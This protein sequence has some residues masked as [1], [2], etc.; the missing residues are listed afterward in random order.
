MSQ[1]SRPR[2]APTMAQMIVHGVFDRFP[3]LQLYFAEINCAYLPAMLYYM[4]RNYH[5]FNDWFQLELPKD[6]VASTSSTTASS[7]W[8]ATPRCCRSAELGMPLDHFGGAATSRTRSARSRTRE[9]YIKEPFAGLDAELRR[10]LLVDNIAA[11]LDL[12]P[13]ADITETPET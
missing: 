2:P 6:A 13:D 5:E 9:Q 3:E 10:T 8:S 1:H 4:D 11:H 7:A 12:D